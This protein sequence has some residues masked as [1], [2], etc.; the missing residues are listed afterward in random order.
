[1]VKE[2]NFS[3]IK[4][5]GVLGE[6]TSSYQYSCNEKAKFNGA[7]AARNKVKTAIKNGKLKNLK[8][9][10]IPCSYCGYRATMY[11]HRDYN[12]PLDVFPVC[13]SCNS[14]LGSAIIKN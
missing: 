4:S 9:A 13:R 7:N 14:S 1:M 5:R 6:H 11:E 8:E 2:L 3:H 12:K 10:H